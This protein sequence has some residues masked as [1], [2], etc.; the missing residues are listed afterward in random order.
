MQSLFFLSTESK[1]SGHASYSSMRFANIHFKYIFTLSDICYDD[2]RVS[3]VVARSVSYRPKSKEPRSNYLGSIYPCIFQNLDEQMM[4][5]RFNLIKP[6]DSHRLHLCFSKL[7]QIHIGLGWHECEWH[8][9]NFFFLGELLLHLLQ[10]GHSFNEL[11]K[12]I[13]SICST[14]SYRVDGWMDGYRNT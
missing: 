5:N 4:M 3:W 1:P 9:Q 10:L 13:T 8:S 14:I 11:N 7:N 6:L 2:V 12:R